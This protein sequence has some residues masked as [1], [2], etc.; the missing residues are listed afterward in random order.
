[1]LKKIN[2]RFYSYFHTETGMLFTLKYGDRGVFGFGKAWYLTV[3]YAG[4]KQTIATF[5]IKDDNHGCYRDDYLGKLWTFDKVLPLARQMV[6]D[7][8][9]GERG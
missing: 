3:I 9:P 6:R 2:E 5:T 1:M 8:L 7:M 4:E